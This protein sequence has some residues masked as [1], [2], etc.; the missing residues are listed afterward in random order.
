[1]FSSSS[2]LLKR[3][4]GIFTLF[5]DLL[6]GCRHPAAHQSRPFKHPHWPRLGYVVCFVCGH[7]RMYD[8]INF[9]YLTRRDKQRL[10]RREAQRSCQEHLTAAHLKVAA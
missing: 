10:E 5:F 8:P 2:L 6:F 3:F 4:P 9:R 1:M 7:E